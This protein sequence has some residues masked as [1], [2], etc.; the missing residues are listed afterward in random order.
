M[1]RLTCLVFYSALI[2][3]LIGTGA[4]PA[5]ADDIH[6]TAS[7]G[8]GGWYRPGGWNP[9]SVTV[10]NSRDETVFGQ[11]QVKSWSQSIFNSSER[12]VCLFARPVAIP[13]NSSR[14]ITVY[15]RGVD[16]FRDRLNL[17]FAE[18]QARGDGRILAQLDN[19]STNSNP[20]L[21]AMPLG[22]NDLLLAGFAGSPG[23]FQS[24]RPQ[25]AGLIIYQGTPNSSSHAVQIAS[26]VASDLPDRAVGYSGVNAFLLRGDST[27]DALSEAQTDALKGWVAYGGHL[28]VFC[29][30]ADPNVFASSFYQDLLPA[31][32][33]SPET[34][35]R[36]TLTPRAIPGV[37]TDLRS[38]LIIAAPY[39]NGWVTVTNIDPSSISPTSFTQAAHVW[40]TL[41]AEHSSAHFLAWISQNEE[42]KILYRGIQFLN[43][44]DVVKLSSS[45]VIHE[46]EMIGI[47][48]IIYL[49]ALV[50]G[51]YL[52]IRKTG[53]KQLVWVIV[54]F[55]T[56]LFSGAAFGIGY[57]ANN[58][59]V[60]VNRAAV[61]EA[62]S[63]QRKAGEYAALGLYSPRRA[64]FDLNVSG[65][66][67]M[68]ALPV[69]ENEIP[70]S[71]LIKF[72]QRPLSTDVLDIPVNMGETRSLEMR[73]TID[74]GGPVSFN[75]IQSVGVSGLITNHSSI[76]LT[77][78]HIY[79]RGQWQSVGSLKQGES[80][81][82]AFGVIPSNP[83]LTFDLP[84]STI[85]SSDHD[86]RNRSLVMLHKL[87]SYLDSL[88]PRET[89][90]PDEALLFGW[91][92]SA[93]LGGL[94]VK[95][96]GHSV[97]ENNVSLVIVHLAPGGK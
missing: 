20:A 6:L 8:L 52:I 70:K 35:G 45:G 49:V 17:S 89:T 41:L 13:G 54:P 78:C 77:D 71:N 18:G 84:Q 96:D 11:L 90:Y 5:T 68:V 66:N 87:A 38:P 80:I 14:S 46:T 75:Q 55:G 32:I 1:A 12:P 37:E 86:P 30:G 51:S 16:P 72:V 58:T 7:G 3:W 63:G 88:G 26:L 50:L 83:T 60:Y 28:V 79:C 19:D 95:V 67:S 23:A 36:L 29:T 10:Q 53:R 94:T 81:P 48:L 97:P 15:T 25:T 33:G 82:I 74:L 57:A 24:L 92:D 61:I 27:V 2:L 64:S 56:L 4:V 93:A 34:D 59:T 47:F 73:S 31:T 65:E 22:E 42:N 76:D 91:C 40:Q 85:P 43:I 69:G 44:S 62:N 9:I 21:T 39:G